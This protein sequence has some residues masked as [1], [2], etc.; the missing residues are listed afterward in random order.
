LFDA[1]TN[2]M[3]E[4][5]FGTSKW[6]AMRAGEHSTSPADSIW[7]GEYWLFVT[8][9]IRPFVTGLSV[10]AGNSML[11]LVED[12]GSE[13]IIDSRP[14]ITSSFN[15]ELE[16][17]RA[18]PDLSYPPDHNADAASDFLSF[19]NSDVAV[20]GVDP[21]EIAPKPSGFKDEERTKTRPATGC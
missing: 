17:W 20:R 4:R 10:I 15:D 9:V 16:Q 14:L 11:R 3:G 6:Q 5:E 21:A 19:I 12:D 18:R 7:H 2:F 8:E 13:C 1:L